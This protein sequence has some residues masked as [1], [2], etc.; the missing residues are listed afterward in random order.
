MTDEVIA[1]CQAGTNQENTGG[2]GGQWRR[3]LQRFLAVLY[4]MHDPYDVES[5]TSTAVALYEKLQE[6][7]S[8]RP[9]MVRGAARIRENDPHTPWIRLGEIHG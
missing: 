2:N 6:F 8:E 9:K 1:A 4:F 7:L 3:V 5:I